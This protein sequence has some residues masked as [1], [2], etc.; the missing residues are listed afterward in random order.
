MIPHTI[1]L[2]FLELNAI[3]TFYKNGPLYYGMI[4][5]LLFPVTSK[6]LTGTVWQRMPSPQPSRYRYRENDIYTHLLF[7]DHPAKLWISQPPWRIRQIEHLM[8]S[9][10]LFSREPGGVQGS[11]GHCETAQY[12]LDH[13]EKSIITVIANP[14]IRASAPVEASTRLLSIENQDIL[15]QLPQDR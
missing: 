15:L 12:P 1:L 10:Q 9:L 7:P 5:L 3:W 2:L 13:R 11:T 8:I 4:S 14:I 6:L